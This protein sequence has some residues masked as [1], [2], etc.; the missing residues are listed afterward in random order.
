MISYFVDTHLQA[1][2]TTSHVI[3]LQYRKYLLPFENAEMTVG[4]FGCLLSQVLQGEGWLI[5]QTDFFIDQ[6]VRLY[7]YTSRPLAAL[8][9]MLAGKGSYTLQGQGK[10][11]LNTNEITFLY[12]PAQRSNWINFTIGYFQSI[13]IELTAGFLGQ[14][15]IED[16]RLKEIYNKLRGQIP[17][18]GQ[19][20]PC[21]LSPRAL[22]QIEKIRNCHIQG[23][24]RLLYCQARIHDILFLYFETLQN[25]DQSSI[26]QRERAIHELAIYIADNLSEPITVPMLAHLAGL[27]HFVL[28]K[29][30]KKTFQQPPVAYIRQK[31]MEKAVSLLMNT[32]QAVTQIALS[33]G[34]TDIAYFSRVF[35]QYFGCAPSE[36]R[37]GKAIHD[38]L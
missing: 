11:A 34:F 18:N 32:S 17:E 4:P 22:E 28:L 16:V 1:Y 24:S 21:A 9:C 38:F 14:F 23:A 3:P 19:M 6:K 30:F 10:I 29:E 33:V 8:H 7:S 35:K 2:T 12:I 25:T 15:I 20:P 13:H 36:Y 5:Q 27:N 31:R 26:T 37:Q